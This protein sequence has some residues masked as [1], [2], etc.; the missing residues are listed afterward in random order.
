MKKIQKKIAEV[1]ARPAILWYLRKDRYY[2]YGGIKVLVKKGVFHPGFFFSTKFFL[3]FLKTEDVSNKTLLELG[4]GSGLIS[5]VCAKRGA[6]VTATD[7]NPAAIE[8]IGES[9]NLNGLT[10]EIYQSDLFINIPAQTFDYIIINPPYYR[11]A[12]KSIEQQAWYAGENLDYFTRLFSTIGPYF[13]KDS[14]VFICLSEDCDLAAIRTIAAKYKYGLKLI[15]TKKIKW[16]ENYVFRL[17][18][19]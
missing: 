15:F 10:V 14:K 6:R 2:D 11:G 18:S 12:A 16:E 7:I 13:T 3:R 19:D 9:A 4:A 8:G 17:T 5:F 1:F